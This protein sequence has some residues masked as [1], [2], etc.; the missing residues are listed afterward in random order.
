MMSPCQVQAGRTVLAIAIAGERLI[1]RGWK[2]RMRS[3]AEPPGG[4]RRKSRLR[5]EFGRNRCVRVS[6]RLRVIAAGDGIEGRVAATLLQRGVR[7]CV[8]V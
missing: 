1:A 5:R 7:V 8:R 2:W 6:L 3:G 4:A